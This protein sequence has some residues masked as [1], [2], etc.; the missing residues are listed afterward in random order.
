[1]GTSHSQIVV[2]EDEEVHRLNNENINLV[3][4][5]ADDQ[6]AWQSDSAT[7]RCEILRLLRYHKAID[8]FLFTRLDITEQ[9]AIY[10]RE[11]LH[12][13]MRQTREN[14]VRLVILEHAYGNNEPFRFSTR[15][16]LD[17]IVNELQ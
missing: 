15:E 6:S 7:I 17:R 11:Q 9:A 5:S 3:A 14:L 12:V 10:L 16:E 1:M 13:T 2:E 8:L 4:S